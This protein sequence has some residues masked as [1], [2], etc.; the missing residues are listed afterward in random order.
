M[1]VQR[2]FAVLAVLATVLQFASASNEAAKPALHDSIRAGKCETELI[3]SATLDVVQ[4]T[5]ELGFFATHVACAVG[6]LCALRNLMS[7]IGGNILESKTA[8]SGWTCLHLAVGKSAR[9]WREH[10][11]AHVFNH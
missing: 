6:N 3:S 4:A 11:F 9:V 1:T 2:L 7:S 10:W 8:S 5:D